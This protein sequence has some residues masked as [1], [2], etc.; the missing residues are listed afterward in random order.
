MAFKR[1]L[2]S[3]WLVRG[4]T[5]LLDVPLPCR[6]PY[7]AWFLAHGDLM[8]LAALSCNLRTWQDFDPKERQFLARFLKPNM[9][10]FDV[11]ANQG[12]YTILASKQVGPQGRVFAFEP[13]P[14]EYRKLRRNVWV[15]RCRNVV[16]EPRAVGVETAVTEFHVCGDGLGGFSSR[17]PPAAD[18]GWVHKELIQVPLVSLDGYAKENHLTSLDFLKIDVE[19]GELDVL[20]GARHYVL[21]R[22]APVV[23]CE[24]SEVRT[25]QWDYAPSAILELMRGLGYEWFG[26]SA[27]GTLVP[28]EVPTKEQKATDNLVAVPADKVRWI[29]TSLASN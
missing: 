25:R 8:G 19:G 7:G 20:E 14:P 26:I 18:V 29:S 2:R 22:L 11:G 27:N 3:L 16:V 4:R 23:M 1:F 9:V 6:L 10:V 5:P 21:P 28:C 17:R 15:N 13:A 12:F 24:V